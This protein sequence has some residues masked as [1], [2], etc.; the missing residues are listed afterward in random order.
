MPLVSGLLPAASEFQPSS[1]GLVVLTMPVNHVCCVA[2]SIVGTGFPCSRRQGTALESWRYMLQGWH[3]L[4]TPTHWH[5][6]Y[7]TLSY[8]RSSMV[9]VTI[10]YTNGRAG[11]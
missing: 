7:P 1:Y 3:T 2:P 9:P 4:Y 11:R 6:S 10:S 8:P 5:T